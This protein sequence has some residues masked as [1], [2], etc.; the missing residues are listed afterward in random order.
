M[1]V[2]AYPADSQGCGTHRI[3]LPAGAVNGLCEPVIGQAMLMAAQSNQPE[4]PLIQQEVAHVRPDVIVFQR[5][6]AAPT[7]Q[8][9]RQLQRTGYAIV[10]DIDDDFTCLPESNPAYRG[11]D[12]KENP[13]ANRDNH[14]LAC[15]FADHLTV[16]T[17]GIASSYGGGDRVSVIRNRVPDHWLNVRMRKDDPAA[18]IWTAVLAFHQDDL[19][20]TGG[21]VGIA[22]SRAGAVFRPMGWAQSC[23]PKDA[24]DAQ[25][26]EA[27]NARGNLQSTPWLNLTTMQFPQFIARA[28]VGIV[29]LADKPFTRSKSCI[30]GLE[31]SALGLPFVASP[32]PEYQW[33]HEQGAGELA[34]HPKQWRLSLERLLRD[35]EWR[36]ERIDAGRET[37]SRLTYSKVGPEWVAAWEKARANAKQRMAA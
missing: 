5:P 29:P 34:E 30:K 18:V 11:T 32:L 24:Y 1:R 7:V 3:L 13:I 26:A 15:S 23:G 20:V 17:P 33:L 9:M 19:E 4:A 37:A 6:M 27:G 8:L 2:L 28:T 21:E 14:W 16:S 10:V 31:Y 22:C 36:Q 35:P 25:L 12:P